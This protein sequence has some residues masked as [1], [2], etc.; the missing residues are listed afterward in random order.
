MTEQQFAD[1]ANRM[2]AVVQQLY[3]RLDDM[4][5]RVEQLELKFAAKEGV[6]KR[7]FRR[8]RSYEMWEQVQNLVEAGMSVRGIATNLGIPPATVY[9]YKNTTEEEAQAFKQQSPSTSPAEQ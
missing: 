8:K 6:S 1:F 5:L 7:E 4:K 3:A 2:T 9:K